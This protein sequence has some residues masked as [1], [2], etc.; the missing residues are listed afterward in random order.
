MPPKA[1]RG[2][3]RKRGGFAGG[4]TID[5]RRRVSYIPASSPSTPMSSNVLPPSYGDMADTPQTWDSSM[6]APEFHDTADPN[7][8]QLDSEGTDVISLSHARDFTFLKD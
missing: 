7:T 6:S 2:R 5:S 4:Q 3:P 8:M 1:Q